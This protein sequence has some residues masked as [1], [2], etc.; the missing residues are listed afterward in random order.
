M[1]L[2]NII[3]HLIDS[4]LESKDGVNLSPFQGMLLHKNG[5]VSSETHFWIFAGGGNKQ[6]WT[7]VS[8]AG[9]LRVPAKL[10]MEQEQNFCFAKIAGFGMFYA[11]YISLCNIDLKCSKCNFFLLRTNFGIR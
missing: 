9:E 2:L 10:R 6:P 11:L 1:D 4:Q 5:N 3:D 8:L 7:N